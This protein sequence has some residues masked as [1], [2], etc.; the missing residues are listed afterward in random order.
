MAIIVSKVSIDI[1]CLR[2]L[3]AKIMKKSILSIQGVQILN[4]NE[5]KMVT[6]GDII[7]DPD[8]CRIQEGC[9]GKPGH[10]PC[11]LK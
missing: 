6:G 5:Q 4:K 1:K 8:P 9:C 11:M 7:F 10:P 3:K 2:R